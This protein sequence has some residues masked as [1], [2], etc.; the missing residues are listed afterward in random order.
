MRVD[1][2]QVHVAVAFLIVAPPAKEAAEKLELLGAHMGKPVAPQMHLHDRARPAAGFRSGRRSGSPADEPAPRRRSCRS[3]TGI[4]SMR[5]SS[6]AGSSSGRNAT[7]ARSPP[8]AA[9]AG[10]PACRPPAPC[11]PRHAPHPP[12][13]ARCSCPRSGERI[14][15]VT[16]PTCARP[17]CRQSPCPTS[18]AASISSPTNLR[19]GMLLPPDQRLAPDEV[20]GLGFQR[21]GKPDPRLERVGLVAEI[22]AREDQPRLDPHHVQRGKAHRLQPQ[23]GRHCAQTAS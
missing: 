20:I 18:T 17:T 1:F 22:I 2:A 10:R 6:A 23:I 7:G 4:G 8:A 13:P 9:S 5:V 21:H 15:D 11:Q 14:D 12:A 16:S 3:W 19:A